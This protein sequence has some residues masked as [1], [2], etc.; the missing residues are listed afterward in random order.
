[1]IVGKVD[2]RNFRNIEEAKVIFKKGINLIYGENCQGKT[3]LLEAV[4]YPLTGKTRYIGS[5]D[6][7]IN[8]SKRN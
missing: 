5:S 8:Y 1:M 2:I 3:N 6:D 7:L 4:Y